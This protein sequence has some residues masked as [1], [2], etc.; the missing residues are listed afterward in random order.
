MIHDL[1]TIADELGVTVRAI[2]NWRA[3]YPNTFPP[4]AGRVGGR[5]YWDDQ[6]L[7]A[8]R[9]WRRTTLRPVGRPP[10]DAKPMD[11][12][13]PRNI[14]HGTNSGFLRHIRWEVPMCDACLEARRRRLTH[15][16]NEKKQRAD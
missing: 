9:I 6:G 2:H 4:A 3:R 11:G 15:L 5:P 13:A 8:I 12:D 7:E 1:T 14:N 16:E 10:I